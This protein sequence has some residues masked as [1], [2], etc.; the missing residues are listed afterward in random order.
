MMDNQDDSTWR[1][2]DDARPLTENKPRKVAFPLP[3]SLGNFASNVAGPVPRDVNDGFPPFECE[4]E[5][6]LP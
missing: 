1:K 4:E 5:P 2:L 3:I 6:P